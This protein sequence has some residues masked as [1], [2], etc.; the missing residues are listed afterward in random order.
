MRLTRQEELLL[1]C[2]PPVGKPLPGV[3]CSPGLGS[4][5]GSV[6]VAGLAPPGSGMMC[7]SVGLCPAGGSLA[8]S[9]WHK[10]RVE[11]NVRQE[12]IFIGS[13]LCHK[14]ATAALVGCSRLFC[15]LTQLSR[16][17]RKNQNM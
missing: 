13:R 14:I 8:F 3:S 4:P 1:L 5:E 7:G 9:H 16:G 2:P 17:A 15:H 6:G 11:I 10:S 12:R